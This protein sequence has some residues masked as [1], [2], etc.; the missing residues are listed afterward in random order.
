VRAVRGEGDGPDISG[1]AEQLYE[2]GLRHA[3]EMITSD[4][5]I[6]RDFMIARHASRLGFLGDCLDIALI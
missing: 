1:V 4:R 6:D 5:V 2:V 3:E